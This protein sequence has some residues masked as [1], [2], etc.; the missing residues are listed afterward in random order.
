MERKIDVMLVNF[1]NAMSKPRPQMPNQINVGGAHIKPNPKPLPADLQTFLDEAKDGV[2]YMS[3]G[4][5]VKSA[6]MPQEKL[7]A[8]LNAFGKLKQRVLWKFENEKLGGVPKNVMI[9][10]WLPQADILAHKNVRMFITHGGMF[11]TT[12]G[13]YYGKPMLFIP[14][15]GDQVR[16]CLY[17]Y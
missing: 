5:F 7:H 17:F 1:H 2:I 13:T 11:G 9:K 4:A 8:F 15:Y 3:L 12:E 16:E 14:F 6:A 10:K